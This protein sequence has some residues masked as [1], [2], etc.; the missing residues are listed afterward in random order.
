MEAV[1]LMVACQKST[2]KTAEGLVQP[3]CVMVKTCQCPQ[4]G[5]DN[6]RH[7]AT[8]L[9]VRQHPIA[10]A[11]VDVKQQLSGVGYY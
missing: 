9:Q 3:T 1:Q 2:M 7:A 5:S 6:R 4:R 10:Y 8:P 11:Y